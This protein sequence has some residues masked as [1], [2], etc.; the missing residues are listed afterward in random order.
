MSETMRDLTADELE[1][2][3]GGFVAG[4]N[5]GINIALT[6]ISALVLTNAVTL[7]SLGMPSGGCPAGMG[8]A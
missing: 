8:C 3:S 5:T 1:N 7:L 4:E 6:G 2:V